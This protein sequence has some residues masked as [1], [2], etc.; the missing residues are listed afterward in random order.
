MSSGQFAIKGS[1]EDQNRHCSPS[2]SRQVNW[3]SSATV[4]RQPEDQR[5]DC[6]LEIYVVFK[7]R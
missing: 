7:G 5:F 6:I 1:E 3:S 4:L 2:A